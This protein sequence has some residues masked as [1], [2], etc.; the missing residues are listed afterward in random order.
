MRTLLSFALALL[1]V[2]MLYAGEPAC[3]E[4]RTYHAAEGKLEAL[5][6]RFRDH[7]TSLFAKHGMTNVAYWTPKIDEGDE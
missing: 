4:L 1:I 2:P 5:Q 3:F 6:S 7:T